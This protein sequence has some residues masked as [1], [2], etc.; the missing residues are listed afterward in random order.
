MTGFGRGSAVGQDYSITI[1][2]KTVN[3]RFLDVSLKLPSELQPIE[4]DLKR[5]IGSRLSRGRVDFSLQYDRNNQINYEINRPLIAG[6]ISAMAEIKSEFGLTG[7]TDVNVIA[8]LPNVLLARKDEVSEAFLN[9]IREATNQAVDNL[10][11]MRSVEGEHLREE[12]LSRINS[13]DE[14]IPVIEKE[15]DTI[16]QEYQQRLEKRISEMLA[17]SQTQVEID[18]GRL[19]Q[20]IAYI[21]DKADISEEITRLRTH[22][23]HFRAIMSEEIEVGKRLDFLTQELNREA[24][25]ISSKTPSLIVK[26]CALKIKSEIEKIREQV[27][28]IE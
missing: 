27:Q 23:D 28:N 17:K 15:S 8:R 12:L 20:E 26:E 2:L 7:E 6:F 9:S 22:L 4:A 10:Q 14:S 3:N 1:D 13:I 21:A 24:N 11:I 18:Q 5:L 19:A 25:T 16:V